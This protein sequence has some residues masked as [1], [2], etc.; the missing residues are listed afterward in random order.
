L[1]FDCLPDEVLNPDSV[2]ISSAEYLA[3][4]MIDSDVE[5]VVEQGEEFK[6][7]LEERGIV[8]E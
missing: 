3:E 6:A 1:Q 8:T 4:D 2:V 7:Y 5:E